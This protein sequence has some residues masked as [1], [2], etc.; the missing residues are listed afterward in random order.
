MTAAPVVI[1]TDG[2]EA[3]RQVGGAVARL[4]RVGDVLL[5]V[6]D[7]GS[8]KTTFAQGFGIF[9]GVAEPVV[10]PTFTLV[11]H[12]PV[13][14]PGAGRARDEADGRA[15]RVSAPPLRQFL[16]ADLYRLSHLHEIEDLGLRELVEDGGVALVEWGEAAEPV[17]ADD[18]LRVDLTADP[19]VEDRRSLRFSAHGGD[20]PGRW[21]ELERALSPWRADR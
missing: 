20:W 13:P 2:P 17:L 9:L 10:S 14:V 15:L 11:R 18:W 3:T 7:L 6:G 16:H 8:G 12:Y 19:T 5:L 4:C 1:G 21:A